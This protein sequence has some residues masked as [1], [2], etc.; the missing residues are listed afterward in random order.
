MRS[1]DAND[2]PAAVE[3]PGFRSNRIWY[4]AMHI[5]FVN[6]VAGDLGGSALCYMCDEGFYG[7]GSFEEQLEQCWFRLRKWLRANKL[8]KVNIRKFDAGVLGRRSSTHMYPVPLGHLCVS[9]S[10]C[11]CVSDLGFC[12]S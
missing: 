10:V 5:F 6:G 11:L 8:G 7:D 12:V 3:M 2:M 9:V 1:L 4:D